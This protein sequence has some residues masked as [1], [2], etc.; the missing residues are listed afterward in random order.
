MRNLVNI[1][2]GFSVKLHHKHNYKNVWFVLILSID[3]HLL[4]Q[5]VLKSLSK[6]M[7]EN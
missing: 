6:T 2:A 4:S 5:L 3:T 1:A 7:S